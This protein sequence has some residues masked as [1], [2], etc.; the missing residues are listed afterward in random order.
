MVVNNLF[1]KQDQRMLSK[2][3][4]FAIEELEGSTSGHSIMK[5]VL[6]KM[7]ERRCRGVAEIQNV[8]KSQNDVIGRPS[9]I[10]IRDL[11]I[12]LRGQILQKSRVDVI[13]MILF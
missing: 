3:L 2:N 8:N 12:E 1:T 7:Y 5:L 4:L 10:F 13:K 6:P 9:S 11:F